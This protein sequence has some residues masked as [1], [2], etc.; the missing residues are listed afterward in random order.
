MPKRSRANPNVFL[1]VPFDEDYE[2]LFLALVAG[3]T[4]LGRVPR[5]VLEIPESGQGRLIRIMDLMRGCGSSIHDL[6][7]VSVKRS[8]DDD[9]KDDLPRFNMPFE[10]G[11]AVGLEP[12]LE[13]RFFVFEKKRFR[14]QRTLSDLSGIDP[15]IH[16]GT[17]AGLIKSLLNCV[18][19]ASGNLPTADTLID[20]TDRLSKA[21]DV[22]KRDCTVDL[23][24]EPHI[25]RG[26]VVAA[27]DLAKEHGLIA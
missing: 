3:L 1:N 5:C 26:L 8:G 7:R 16:E 27:S 19:P 9:T 6:S 24:F 21:A 23:I 15:E 22:L 12:E 14:L 20:L 4:G 2:P 25:Y 13:H 17:Q 18:L 10:L 11:I